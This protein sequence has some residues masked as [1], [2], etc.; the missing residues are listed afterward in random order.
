MCNKS[1]FNYVKLSKSEKYIAPILVKFEEAIIGHW[2]EGEIVSQKVMKHDR[3]EE[4]GEV[5][6]G[7]SQPGNAVCWAGTGARLSNCEYRNRS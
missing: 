1:K 2:G 3:G 7:S 4:E 6:I 5:L